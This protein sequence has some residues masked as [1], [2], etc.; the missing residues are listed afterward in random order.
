MAAEGIA[1]ILGEFNVINAV[2]QDDD[3]GALG[4]RLCR[5]ISQSLNEELLGAV[6]I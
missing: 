1:R 4:K 2:D 5:N 3:N 6:N